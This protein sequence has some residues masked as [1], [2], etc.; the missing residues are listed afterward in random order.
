MVVPEN[1]SQLVVVCH[2]HDE[3]S[4]RLR[5]TT[6]ACFDDAVLRKKSRSRSSKIQNNAVMV[7]T[8][9]G[10]LEWLHE[11]QPVEKKD[12][13]TVCSAIFL[14]LNGIVDSINR[15]V[16]SKD[17]GTCNVRLIHCV[18]GKDLRCLA[19]VNHS[20]RFVPRLIPSSSFCTSVFVFLF[21]FCN[22]A[23][24]FR[25]CRPLSSMSVF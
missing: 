21:T 25:R 8:E 3:A 5:S 15:S 6:A 4:M 20:L 24:V 23:F 12:A 10:D 2:I 19:V 16:A 7:Y 9:D 14:V 18:V 1:G 11:L 13:A 22:C 17:V